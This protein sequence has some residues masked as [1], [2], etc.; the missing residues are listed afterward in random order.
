MSDE[1]FEKKKEEILKE[2]EKKDRDNMIL[3]EIDYVFAE[4]QDLETI[5]LKPSQWLPPGYPLLEGG[6]FA[7]PREEVASDLSLPVPREAAGYRIR[8]L[9]L[10]NPA[11]QP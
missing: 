8:V 1:D 3:E 9:Y 10:E 5:Y 11:S 7:S 4:N 2:L 6:R